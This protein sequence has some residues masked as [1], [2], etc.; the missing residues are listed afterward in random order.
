[1]SEYTYYKRESWAR[2]ETIDELSYNEIKT[3]GETE[4]EWFQHGYMLSGDYCG[5]GLIACSNRD[6]LAERFSDVENVLWWGAVGSYGSK[7]VW[8]HACILTA[9]SG[10]AREIREFLEGLD[11]YPLADESHHSELEHEAEGEAW[12]D[13]G[14]SDFRSHLAKI[15]PHHDELLRK[16]PKCA[17][18]DVWSE[19]AERELGGERC[20]H[21]QAGC[22]FGFDTVFGDRA[23]S[24]KRWAWSDVRASLLESLENHRQWAK[25]RASQ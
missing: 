9:R 5:A 14:A 21:E 4:A 8:F 15:A 6:V 16:V 17:L 12:E 7:W 19:I 10:K 3:C 11:E 23:A 20:I 22:Y 2:G 24:H 25:E 13:Y 1:M 18:F